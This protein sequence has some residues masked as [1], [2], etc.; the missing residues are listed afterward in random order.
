MRYL[1]CRGEK[2]TY[3]ELR[4]VLASVIVLE[5]QIEEGQI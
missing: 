5:M 2:K 3:K 4:F 1:F